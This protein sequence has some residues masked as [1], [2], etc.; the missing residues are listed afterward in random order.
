VRYAYSMFESLLYDVSGGISD[1]RYL[2]PKK[3]SSLLGSGCKCR[4]NNGS[5]KKPI[6][7]NS[8]CSPKIL[9]RRYADKHRKIR[10][11]I[12]ATK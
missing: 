4:T 10:L 12:V 2:R 6:D 9:G 11:R 7:E 5:Q 3:A 1:S 8:L